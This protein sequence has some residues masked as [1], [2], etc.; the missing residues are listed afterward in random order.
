MNLKI[1]SNIILECSSEQI[2]NRCLADNTFENPIFKSNELNH[3]SNW[4]TER[5]I[6]TYH[7]EGERLI[8]PRGYMRDIL[9]CFQEINITPQVVDERVTNQCE[10]PK[11]LNRINLRPYQK[12][13]VDAAMKFDQGTIISPTGSGKTLI[14][15]EIIRKRSQR[16][17]IIVHRTELAK[18]WIRVIN[19]RLGLKAGFIGDGQWSIGGQITVAIVQTLTAKENETKLLSS[20]FGLI[21]IDE[22]HHVPA[23]TFFDVISL[24]NSKYRY[25]LSASQNRRDG[26]EK[27]IYLCVGPVITEIYRD[28]VEELGATV[29][30]TIK[31][32]ETGFSPSANSWNEYL[33]SITTNAD[34]NIGIISLAQNSKASTLILVD[35]VSHAQQISAMLETRTID[36][37]M[38]HGQICKKNRE[39]V[40]DRIKTVKITVGTTSL[41]GEGLDISSW[42]T[43]I[44]G[45]PISSEI[46]LMQAIGRIVRPLEGKEKAIVYDLKDDCGFSGASFN[47]RFAIYKKH[48]IWVEFNIN[49]KAV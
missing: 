37:V 16:A 24:F 3:R 17:L 12:Q 10:Y 34:R 11:N 20:V 7:F 33:D 28:E 35:R 39:Y 43:L 27:M 30:T 26:L 41:I 18:Q 46:K 4:D 22:V 32:I 14:G 29:P 31:V 40:M 38:A 49:K 5:T 9:K 25:G 8:L 47:K 45:S 48:N 23:S 21:L 6:T 36:H 15:L 44:I 2:I 42:D 13:A 1:N 19:E